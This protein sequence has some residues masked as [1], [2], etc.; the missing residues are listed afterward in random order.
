MST[1][2]KSDAQ[3]DFSP[4]RNL[5]GKT[6]AILVSEWHSEITEALFHAASQTI[7]SSGVDFKV[8]RQNVPGSFELS[9]A[10]QYFAQLST[11][12]AVICLGCVIQGETRHFEFIC[13][14]I[15]KGITDVSL[16]YNK[17]VSF[18]VITSDDYEQA[19]DRAGG[20]LGNKGE[21]AA[22]AVIKMLN[23]A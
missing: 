4:K 10:S 3:S 12:D 18:G 19:K 6:I 20:K 16:K 22:W 11:V 1:I 2:L 13:N 5:N 15:A 23:I 8:I 7:S 14:A 17:P 9:L 21:E